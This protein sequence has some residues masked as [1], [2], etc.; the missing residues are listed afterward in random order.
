MRSA[1]KKPD[2]AA[3]K[4][5]GGASHRAANR[6]KIIRP[7]R[8]GGDS[9][10]PS[11]LVMFFLG[12]VRWLSPPATFHRHSV[13]FQSLEPTATQLANHWK[14]ICAHLRKSVDHLSAPSRLCVR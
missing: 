8:G 9:I 2:R 13:A 12:S 4:V 3:G 10:A 14:S 6:A 7:G 5:A 1:I 11:G